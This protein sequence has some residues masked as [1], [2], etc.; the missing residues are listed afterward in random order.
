MEDTLKSICRKRG[1]SLESVAGEL[2]YS[3]KDLI[4]KSNEAAN[5]LMKLCVKLSVEPNDFWSEDVIEICKAIKKKSDLSK[6]SL[7]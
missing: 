1:K 6:Q 5:T 3:A 4:K 2:G 7:K